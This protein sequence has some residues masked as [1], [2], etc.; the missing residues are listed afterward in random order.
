[1]GMADQLSEASAGRTAVRLPGHWRRTLR[2]HLALLLALKF[3]ALALL[4]A[5]CFSGAH[6]T[7]VDRQAAA[8][9]LGLV[10]PAAAHR[11]TAPRVDQ[12]RE[13]VSD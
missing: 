2:R 11:A 12:V 13:Q 8:A 6:R 7:L 3:A 5:L 9:R 4:W 1:M 10:Q